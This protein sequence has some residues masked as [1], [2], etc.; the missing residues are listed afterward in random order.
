MK[1]KS[2]KR[3]NNKIF[4]KS[5]YNKKKQQYNM[6]GGMLIYVIYTAK[7]GS[8]YPFVIDADGND[9][10]AT[11]KI[12]ILQGLVSFGFEHFPDYEQHLYM[13]NSITELDN[14]QMI[15]D[16][17][18]H[19]Q[20]TSLIFGPPPPQIIVQDIYNGPIPRG[21]I[22]YTDFTRG[23]KPYYVNTTTG[24]ISWT[25]PPQARDIS[26]MNGQQV[27]DELA[28]LMG[29]SAERRTKL[30]FLESTPAGKMFLKEGKWTQENISDWIEGDLIG[31]E[32]T[33]AVENMMLI[34]TNCQEPQIRTVVW[35]Q[36]WNE[37][38][39]RYFYVTPDKVPQL[40]FP[41]NIPGCITIVRRYPSPPPPPLSPP[42]L[43]HQFNFIPLPVRR[44]PIPWPVLSPPPAP[45]APLTPNTLSSMS[46]KETIWTAF[47][48]SG[49]NNYTHFN[50]IF[51]TCRI[52]S[53]Y[54][55]WGP[56]YL[57][58]RLI[59]V[60]FFAW[61]SESNPIIIQTVID[62]LLGMATEAMAYEITQ[63]KK[64]ISDIESN[65]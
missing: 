14:A 7:N 15:S 34:K 21:W 18:Q 45:P 11:F 64:Q 4:K 20:Q 3:K 13:S 25:I 61:I 62:E 39:Q 9:N 19:D 10:V 37:T 59:E 35:K 55:D 53:D 48:R 33:R 28:A 30:K 26:K 38:T 57:F 41:T 49:L 8:K 50:I 6:I 47:L 36:I 63:I 60:P 23:N 44:S 31:K 1:K 17:F 16:C 58:N 52:S 2:I 27:A 43:H 54:H 51:D 56:E 5:K 46:I 42:P 22:E 12:R 24:Q 40:E 29:W 65:Q 32:K